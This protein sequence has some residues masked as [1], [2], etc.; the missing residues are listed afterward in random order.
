MVFESL[1]DLNLA[2]RTPWSTFFFGLVYSSF[3]IFLARYILPEYSSVVMVFF[4]TLFF[5]PLF[6]NSFIS[7]E[8]KD[9]D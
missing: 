7:E 3:S 6:Y 4:I 5:I 8:A 2:E 1:L 9:L